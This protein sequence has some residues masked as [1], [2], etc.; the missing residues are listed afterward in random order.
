MKIGTP[1]EIEAAQ[2]EARARG[3]T[4]TCQRIVEMR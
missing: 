3:L 2:A 4:L 1:A